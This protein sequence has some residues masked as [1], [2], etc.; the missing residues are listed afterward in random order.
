MD[1]TELGA[2]IRRTRVESGISQLDLARMSKLSRATVNYVEQGSVAIGADALLRILHTLGLSIGGPRTSQGSSA[3]SLLAATA[4][5]SFRDDI[6]TEEVERVLISGQV[7]EQWLAHIATIID[8]TS[9][10][11]L[12]RAVREIAM[13]TGIS[14]SIIWRNLKCLSAELASPHERWHHAS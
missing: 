10:A 8:E 1:L 7:E 2:T 11:M 6:S 5:V 12:L 4:S 9:N 14:S 3:V 13:R